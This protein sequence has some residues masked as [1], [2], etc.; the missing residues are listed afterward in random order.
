MFRIQ[1]FVRHQKKQS[2][3]RG[4]TSN[5]RRGRVTG[6]GRASPVVSSCFRSP[7]RGCS[8]DDPS[9]PH[10]CHHP[11]PNATPARICYLAV[12]A[13]RA[14]ECL[15]EQTMGA[16][17]FAL[18]EVCAIPRPNRDIKLTAGQGLGRRKGTSTIL[19]IPMSLQLLTLRSSSAPRHSTEP[20]RRPI[21]RST[22]CP[23]L[24]RR[25]AE[26]VC[27]DDTG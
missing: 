26:A 1:T 19:H 27:L 13:T 10:R 20:S 12:A 8:I 23:T 17:W 5:V 9:L 22:G 4:S 3:K 2:M 14:C 6:A 11:S 25:M 16:P 21:A 24:N 15:I 7:F 18:F